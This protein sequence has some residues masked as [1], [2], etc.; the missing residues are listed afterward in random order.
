MQAEA[1]LRYAVAMSLDGYIA[2]PG[3]ETDW[4]INDPAIDFAEVWSQFDTLLMGRRTYD[5]A[6]ARL[7]AAAFTSHHTVVVST[8]LRPED[9]ANITV[10]PELSPQSL[11]VLRE[12]S[13]KDI[14]LMGGAS[15]AS[16]ILEL[17]E[18]DSID[19]N[20]IPV[21][22]GAGLSLASN[23]RMPIALKLLSHTTYPSGIVSL[24]YAVGR[25]RP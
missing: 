5:A 12:G 22:L 10:L 15:L 4:I 23:L 25:E 3:G 21:L 8:T 1:K 20:V 16:S 2:G 14:W 17:G 19:L 13:S 24:L 7:G 6:R 9:N 11:Q 18:L